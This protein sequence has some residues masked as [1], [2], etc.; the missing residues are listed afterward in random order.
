MARNWNKYQ[1]ENFGYMLDEKGTNDAECSRKV[2]NGRKVAGVIKSLVN[3]KE[4]S[5]ECARVLHEGMLLPVLLYSSETMVWNK[6]YRS[7]VQCVQIDNIRGVLGVRR[8]N[9]IR[10][11]RIRELCGVKKGI[12]ERIN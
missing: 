4:L 1:F 7:K 5:L 2:V 10:N 3:V 6:K 9:K 12:N 11:Y 8:I